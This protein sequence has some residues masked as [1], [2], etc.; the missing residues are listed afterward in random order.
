MKKTYLFE[1][2]EIKVQ[3]E[4]IKDETCKQ[5]SFSVYRKD[6]E[7]N[8][9]VPVNFKS[10][11]QIKYLIFDKGNLLEV[12]EDS[13][14]GT[15]SRIADILKSRTSSNSLSIIVSIIKIVSAFLKTIIRLFLIKLFIKAI[16]KNINKKK[17]EKKESSETEGGQKKDG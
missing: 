10:F 2:S 15:I 1:N 17:N 12:G 7:I 8:I 5:I 9:N 11:K 4:I 16:T 13:P 3:T 14:L 6:L